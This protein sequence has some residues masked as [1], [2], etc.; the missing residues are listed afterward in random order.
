MTQTVFEQMQCYA[1]LGGR[2]GFS[3]GFDSV[4]QDQF[5]KAEVS[6]D[7]VKDQIPVAGGEGTGTGTDTNP[8][9]GTDAGTEE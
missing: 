2:G 5:K 6:A 8:A 4:T 3:T 1:Q 7:E 9:D